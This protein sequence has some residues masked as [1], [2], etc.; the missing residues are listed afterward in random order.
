M[1]NRSGHGAIWIRQN[2]AAT[3]RG[4]ETIRK[5]GNIGRQ[6]GGCIRGPARPQLAGHLQCAPRSALATDSFPEFILVWTIVGSAPA[7]GAVSSALAGNTG[8]VFDEGVEHDSRGGCAPHVAVPNFMDADTASLPVLES[9]PAVPAKPKTPVTAD[10]KF[11]DVVK[12]AQDAAVLVLA[13][14]WG[15]ATDE[16]AREDARPTKKGGGAGFSLLIYPRITRIDTNLFS[17]RVNLRNSRMVGRRKFS[18]RN[19]D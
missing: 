9:V 16:P 11:E 14:R 3:S 10:R 5:A 15:E 18:S 1:L 6:R 19:S 2:L 12:S 8:D 4:C 17:I 7:T 13:L